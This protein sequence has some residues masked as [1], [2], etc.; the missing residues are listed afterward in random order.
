MNYSYF[1]LLLYFLS[2]E[3]ACLYLW[4]EKKRIISKLR[5]RIKRIVRIL[6]FYQHV[7]YSDFGSRFFFSSLFI[8][9]L[10]PSSF[11]SCVL[12]FCSK[13]ILASFSS[14]VFH[15]LLPLIPSTIVSENWVFR[16]FRF[17]SFRLYI[18]FQQHFVIGK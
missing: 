18:L 9:L 15:H 2:I 11:V 10:F 3:L 16:S 14:N 12:F 6:P 5:K 17:F 8:F 7:N 1:L 4:L 13:M